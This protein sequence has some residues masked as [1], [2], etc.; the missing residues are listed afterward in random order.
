VQNLTCTGLSPSS[1]VL[2]KTF[3]FSFTLILQSYN[4]GSAVTEPV[5]A[6]PR[7]LAT[8]YGITIVFSSSGYLDVSVHRVCLLLLGYL[9]FNQ[10][11]CP[12]R[13]S[14]DQFVCANPRSLS[15]LITSFFASESLGILH[16]PLLTFSVVVL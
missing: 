13:K 8:T 12:I 3:Q 4:P 15:Q 6:S 7:S 14:A 16:T 5:W 9:I 1:I 10:V 11:G 2:S